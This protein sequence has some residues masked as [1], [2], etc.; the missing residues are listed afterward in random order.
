[1]ALAVAMMPAP[2]TRR[3]PCSNCG[4]LFLHVRVM[5]ALSS[6]ADDG[7]GSGIGRSF[8]EVTLFKLERCTHRVGVTASAGFELRADEVNTGVALLA[9]LKRFPF[10]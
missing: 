6:R 9:G 3:L 1:M 5:Q 10:R 4:C 8:E 2:T 7:N